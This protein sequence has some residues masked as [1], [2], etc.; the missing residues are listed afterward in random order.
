MSNILIF[1]DMSVIDVHLYPRKGFKSRVHSI[2]VN[3]AI[4]MI[5]YDDLTKRS[6]VQYFLVFLEV[7]TE[8]G[9]AI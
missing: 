5:K 3:R 7:Y 6:S 2:K 9:K 4:C 1:L 8:M